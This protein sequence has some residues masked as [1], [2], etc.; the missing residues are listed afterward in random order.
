MEVMQ[1]PFGVRFDKRSRGPA[2]REAGPERVCLP[3]PHPQSLP[4]DLQP[5]VFAVP[6]GGLP[7]AVGQRGGDGEPQFVDGPL[8]RANP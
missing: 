4:P 3:I 1:D 6:P 2:L 7:Q 8:R 5:P